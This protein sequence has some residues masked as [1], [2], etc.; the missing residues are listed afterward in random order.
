MALSESSRV[1]P[2]GFSEQAFDDT[3]DSISKVVGS[4]NVSRDASSGNLPGPAGEVIYGDVWPMS[5][6]AR[7]P[8]GAIR[9][10]TTEEVQKVLKVATEHGLPLWT[11]SR[12]KNLG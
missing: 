6:T 1:L 8:S 9:P 7:A 11:T 10:A 3:L 2:P 4:E 12:G 5:G